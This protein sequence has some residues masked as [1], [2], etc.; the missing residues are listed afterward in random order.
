MIKVD[1]KEQIRRAYYLEGKSVRQIHRETGYHRDTIRKALADGLIPEYALKEPR[2]TPVLAPV[3]AIID[4]W[5]EKDAE[6][7]RKQRHTAKRI[8]DRLKAEYGFQGAE[9]TIRRYVGQRRRELSSEVFIPLGYEP[10]QMA[11]V[12]FGEAQVVISGKQLSSQLFCLRM[13]YSRQPFVMALPNQSQEAFFEGHVRAFDFLGGVPNQLVYDNLKTA[14]KDVLEG[15][16]REEQ[17]PLTV[18][19]RGHRFSVTLSL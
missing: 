12:D 5:L 7:P 6:Q 4:E 3:K 9:S 14:V 1:K 17:M 16:N 19:I 15:R 11:Q 2:P 13:C 8:Y 18:T 10:G